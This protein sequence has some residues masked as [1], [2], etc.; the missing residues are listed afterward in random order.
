MTDF[1]ETEVRTFYATMAPAIKQTGSE[2][3]GP[4]PVHQ[5]KDPNFSVNANTG[6]AHC[7]SKCGRGFDVIGL[8][9]ELTGADFPTAKAKVFEIV[10][11]P[12]PNWEERDIEA[13]YDYQDTDGNVLY[14]VVRKFGKKFMQRRP[15]NQGGWPWGL[16]GIA[17]VPFHLPRWK[18]APFVAVTEGEKDVLTLESIGLKATC[19]NGGAGNFKPELA[20]WFAGKKVAII[21]D[22]DDPGR[23]HAVKVAELLNPVALSVKIIELPGLEE[24]GDV[25]DYIRAGGTR[26]AIA[27]LYRKAQQWTPEWEFSAEVP[28]PNEKYIRTLQQVLDE[29]GGLDKFWSMP[30][31]S[32]IATPFP[33][34]TRCLGGG[35]RPGEVYVIGANQG[36]GKTS[37]ALQF[38]LHALQKRFGVLMFSMEMGWKDVYQRLISIEARVDLLEYRNTVASHSSARAMR[39]A[40]VTA[41]AEAL[42]YQLVVSNKTRVNPDYLLEEAT[43]IKKRSKVDLIVIDHMQLMGSTGNVRGD[44]EKFT[45]I[46]RATKETAQEMGVP[47]LL[48]SQTSRSNST[49]RRSELEVSDLRGSGAIEEDAAAVM[50][51]YYDRDDKARTLANGTFAKGPVKSFLKVDKNRYGMQG[52]YM[53]LM[54]YKAYTRFEECEQAEAAGGA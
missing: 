54:H 5:G 41:T 46:S 45:A 48:V 24:K 26:E 18:D 12:A 9:R 17:P 51:L 20:K 13:M 1:T 8:Y 43:R 16:G 19:N 21:P 10:G 53:P 49:E 30:E 22:N 38:A 36:A 23:S 29:C 27:E 44:Y 3:R 15:D 28:N 37:L 33:K 4:C 39:E 34:L 11:R 7:H 2:W 25:S 42:S 32:G 47:I 50:L 40:L 31:L 35:M 6:F 52:M 14:Q